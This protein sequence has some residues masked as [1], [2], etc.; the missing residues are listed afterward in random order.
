MAIP[1]GKKL[2]VFVERDVTDNSPM[3]AR[4]SQYVREAV[5]GEFPG[6]QVLENKF[7]SPSLYTAAVGNVLR[8][9]DPALEKAGFPR[10][11]SFE[12]FL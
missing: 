5:E 3:F 12:V 6:A 7:R 11:H 8:E 9:A 10:Q 2:L 4:M 1:A